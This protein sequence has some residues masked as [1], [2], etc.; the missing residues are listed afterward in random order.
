[1]ALTPWIK[2]NGIPAI[3][4]GA[5]VLCGF[6]PCNCLLEGERPA[7]LQLTIPD[8]CGFRTGTHLLTNTGNYA[9]FNLATGIV[10]EGGDPDELAGLCQIWWETTG[11]S[12]EWYVIITTD[13]GGA[14]IASARIQKTGAGAGFENWA[15]SVSFFDWGDMDGLTIPWFGQSGT[16]Q[17]TGV[18]DPVLVEIPP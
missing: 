16:S 4:D 9:A 2:D 11:I 7:E 8:G 6:C 12:G 18:P 5:P 13:D 14:S 10:L 3:A 1:M 15:A 17:C